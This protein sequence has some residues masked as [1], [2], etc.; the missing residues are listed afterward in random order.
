MKVKKWD[1]VANFVVTK[2]FSTLKWI[3]IHSL[4][5]WINTFLYP[6]AMWCCIFSIYIKSNLTKLSISYIVLSKYFRFSHPKSTFNRW[7]SF[8]LDLNGRNFPFLGVYIL[9]YG[10][11]MWMN[12]KHMNGKGLLCS[13]RSF[14]SDNS[15]YPM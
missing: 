1:K 3:A 10:M 15:L 8:S 7:K 6:L 11:E 9:Q 4:S 14:A 5:L 2:C 12:I 13:N